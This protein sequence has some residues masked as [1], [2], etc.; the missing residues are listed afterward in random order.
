MCFAM[1]LF[2]IT[3]FT[4]ILLIDSHPLTLFGNLDLPSDREAL[5]DL[6][7][8]FIIDNNQ[9]DSNA[10]VDD[11]VVDDDDKD[12]QESVLLPRGRACSIEQG[13]GESVHSALTTRLLNIRNTPSPSTDAAKKTSG[14]SAAKTKVKSLPSATYSEADTGRAESM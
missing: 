13:P 5:I 12:T 6:E 7:N 10:S 11:D 4:K 14:G 9:C 1:N 2:L 3:L 8:T